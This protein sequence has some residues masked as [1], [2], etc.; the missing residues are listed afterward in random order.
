MVRRSDEI[1]GLTDPVEN[2]LATV[3]TAEAFP[4]HGNWTGSAQLGV[5]KLNNELGPNQTLLK[6]DEWWHPHTWT[7]SLWTKKRNPQGP[8]DNAAP[9]TTTVEVDF[10]AGGA[11][12]TLKVDFVRG[13]MLTLPTN[14]IVV[15]VVK[16]SLDSEIYAQVAIGPRGP[17]G[18]PQ[19]Q[20]LR[21][22]A[23]AAGGVS[24]LVEIPPFT[25]ELRVT[26]GTLGNILDPLVFVEFSRNFNAP[27]TIIESTPLS[28]VTGNYGGLLQIPSD[29]VAFQIS[30]TS[31]AVVNVNVHARLGV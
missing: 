19:F 24:P 16:S 2:P 12:Q 31:A 13:T 18:C 3:R 5:I 26:R 20:L 21:N 27:P 15:R 29:A 8:L 11:T 6:T 7:L 22:Q 4:A 1:F 9:L 17:C 28:V 25:S 10:G 30:N 23:V 14:S